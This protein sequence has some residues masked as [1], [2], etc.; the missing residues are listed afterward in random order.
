MSALPDQKGNAT[1]DM[2]RRWFI[3]LGI[4]AAM[5]FSW[6]QEAIAHSGLVSSVPSAGANLG[7]S[8]A[9][10]QLSFSESP[11]PAHSTIVVTDRSGTSYERGSPSLASDNRRSLVVRLADLDRGVYTVNWRV[12]SKADGHATSGT[13]AF[14][15]RASPSNGVATQTTSAVSTLEV[16]GRWLLVVG[17]VVLLGIATAGIAGFDGGVSSLSLIWAAVST[18]AVGVVLTAEA[19]RRGAGVGIGGVFGTP[20]GWALVW[21]TVAVGVAALGLVA[22]RGTERWRRA[23]R[24]GAAVAVLAGMAAHVASGHAA[25]DSAYR[26]AHVFTQWV[27]FAGAGVWL[28]GLTALL[29]G[30]RGSASGAKATAVRRF[31]SVAAIGL[32]VVAVT[33]IIRA[34]GQVSAWSELTG[35]AYGRTILVKGGLIVGLAGLGALNRWW[36]IPVAATGLRRLRRTSANE[37]GLAVV[38]IAA[39][40]LLGALPTP[41]STRPAPPAIVATGNDFA[42]AVRARLS[43]ASAE[44]G[45]NTFEVKVVDYDSG[46]PVRAR[47]VSL[48]FTCAEDPGLPRTVLDLRPVADGTYVGSGSNIQLEGRWKVRALVELGS[49]STAV[50]FE[51]ESRG[52]Q[53]SVSIERPP[54]RPFRYTVEIVEGASVLIYARPQRPGRNE[55]FLSYFD[56]LAGELPVD[57]VVVTTRGPSGAVQ[58]VSP[59][60]V[61]PGR[62]LADLTFESGTTTVTAISRG[63]PQGR[64][65]ASVDLEIAGR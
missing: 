25:A 40:A 9:T 28:G 15:V 54:G 31:S 32:V 53:P 19:Q 50:P 57:D 43:V 46:E 41:A 26:A 20:V 60:R 48:R 38:V 16:V 13:Y 34:I 12:V 61:G 35:T 42:T 22:S 51:I 2:L 11:D 23:A 63:R 17:M 39:T 55:V 33:G 27:H 56:V 24:S 44:P 4:V 14:G 65:R 30:V 3:T 7:A 58:Q 8:P 62:F 10:L 1:P 5:L 47:R 64:L 37:L 29:V 21:R 59:R 49:S 6:H 36:S 45:P 52:P 18:S